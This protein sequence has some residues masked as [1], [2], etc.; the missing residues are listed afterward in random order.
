MDTKIEKI[1]DD[2]AKTAGNRII[3]VILLGLPAIFL[4][5]LFMREKFTVILPILYLCFGVVIGIMAGI[6]LVNKKILEMEQES[7]EVV[8]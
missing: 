3:V 7:N 8:E 4:A 5:Y 6:L 1:I 2:L